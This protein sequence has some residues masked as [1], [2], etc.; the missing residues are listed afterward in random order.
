MRQNRRNFLNLLVQSEPR[1]A[2]YWL[3]VNRTAMACR[4]EVTMR[5]SEEMG[6]A[7]AT[8]ALDEI[9]RLESRLTVFRETS[10]VSVVNSE[11]AK[12]SIEVSQELFDLLT[13]CQHLYEETDGAFDVTSG[14]LTR[15]WGF[16]RRQ[17][18]LPSQVEIDQ[19]MCVVGSDKLLLDETKRT[20][21]FARE[22][23]EINLGS[24]GKGYALDSAADLMSTRV[25]TALLNAGSSSMRAVG[26]GEH[27]KGWLVG[28]RNPRSKLRRLGVLR[29]RDC[30]LSTSGSEEQFFEHQGQRYS[31]IIDP[32]SGW[33]ASGVTSVSVVAPT[34]AISDALATAFFVG[35][36]QLAEPYCQTHTNVLAIMLESDGAAPISFG[37]SSGCDGLQDL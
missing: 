29:L 2:S 21:R 4:F 10:E 16:L 27:G 17:G 34:A 5:Q 18:Q 1:A 13:L 11:A 33:P 15:S 9:D 36:R 6:I 23:M 31:H 32:R 12:R 24:I 22:G 19:A 20:V 25:S 35:G 37:Q 3:H 30:A 14:P 28:L 26:N 7:A 8:E